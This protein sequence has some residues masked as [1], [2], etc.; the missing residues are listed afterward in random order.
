MEERLRQNERLSHRLAEEN[1]IV[2]R[3]GRPI[4]STL[5]LEEVFEGFA[6]EVQKVIFFD[7]IMIGINN[8]QDNTMTV[9][10]ASGMDIEGRRPG[11]V[12]PIPRAAGEYL[13]RKQPGRIVRLENK[14]QSFERYP[15]AEVHFQAGIRSVISIPLIQNDAVIDNL[16]IQSVDPD[17]YT[18]EHLELAVRIG[19]QIAGAIGNAQLFVERKRSE[20]KLKDSEEKY[21]ILVEC[22]P[23]GICL[24]QQ[25]RLIFVNSEMAEGLG[26]S[27]KELTSLSF[28]DF[29]YPDD[30][31]MIA[32]YLQKRSKGQPSPGNS[33]GRLLH[34]DGS[35][36]WRRVDVATL[37][38]EDQPLQLIFWVDITY[39]V[40]EEKELSKYRAH[41]EE[42]VEQRT[43]NL[44]L[45][46]E[47]LQAEITVHL[48]TKQALYQ[49]EKYYRDMI[50]TAEEGVGLIDRVGKTDYVNPRMAD[51]LGYAVED[52][53]GQTITSFMDRTAQAAWEQYFSRISQ[54]KKH[55]SDFKFR[56]KHG[57][58]IWTILASTPRFDEQ[59]EFAGALLM[60]TD[61]TGRREMEKKIFQSEKLASLG[62]LITSIAHEIN[63]L[64][65]LISFNIPVLRDYLQEIVP[66]LYDYA[67][68]HPDHE[69]LGMDYHEFR[70]DISRLLGNI[71]HG[72]DRIN[73]VVSN[74]RE[75]SRKKDRVGFRRVHLK[76]V[77]ERRMAICAGELTKKVKSVDINVSEN[78]PMV[79]TDLGAVEQIL[80]NLLVNAIQAT[81]KAA[82]WIRVRAM[83]A[84][85]RTDVVQADVSDNGCGMDENTLDRIFDFFYT[86]KPPGT[87]TG[88]GLYVSQNL[89]HE[90]GACRSTG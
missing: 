14:K 2:A 64:N 63:N 4:G 6:E 90:L 53:S 86:T 59:R 40:E 38:S 11:S 7:R 12:I 16:Y 80:I 72:T 47:R 75:F 1:R 89:I 13:L 34:K 52:F 66:I 77:V 83:L 61:I 45:A 42:L 44:V 67:S 62:L 70:E 87:G 33:R 85:S 26:Y 18:E 57:D 69:L 36:S 76:E 17:A 31:G 43:A 29:V 55:R 9:G 51:T 28:F 48:R 54:E 58:D 49:S 24:I 10:Y 88:P 30:Q 81:D 79:F 39:R 73:T 8:V 78:I 37:P 46:T 32:K 71:E 15:V 60:V 41:L 25:E 23:L 68:Q 22:A 5:N 27:K 20:E 21:R 19:A 65:K 56:N 35:I 82:S 3:I 74:L 84:P 50:D